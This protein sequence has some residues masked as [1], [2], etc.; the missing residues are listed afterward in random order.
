[1]KKQLVLLMEGTDRSGKSTIGKMVAE[2]LQ[3]PYFKFARDKEALSGSEMTSMMLKYADPYF[4]DFLKQTKTSVVIDRHYPS[5]WVYSHALGRSTDEE[6]IR[7]TD[8]LFS[9]IPTTVVIM[10]RKSYVG[11]VDD[12]S[13]LDSD[14]LEM[15]S[16]KYS[17]FAKWSKCTVI[18][19]EFD[20]WDPDE[21]AHKVILSLGDI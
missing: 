13:R 7:E 16:K 21:M 11:V 12:D 8:R 5:E 1:M 6:R 2:R 18:E 3:I 20:S 10:K 9:E 19:L 14:R 17:D 15:I 4:C